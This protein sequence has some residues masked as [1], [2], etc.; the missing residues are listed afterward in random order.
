LYFIASE[1]ADGSF[2]SLHG[3]NEVAEDLRQVC[4]MKYYPQ[5]IMNY[6]SCIAANYSNAG[7]IWQTC[8]SSNGIDATQIQE[9]STGDEGNALLSDNIALSNY[10]G[11]YESPTLLLNNN[12]LVGGYYTTS[13]EL[14]KEV[15][16]AY[17]PAL[18]GCNKTLSGEG[19]LNNSY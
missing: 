9:C 4:I 18:N 13:A 15:V 6:T 3:A 8:A 17:N 12:T 19:I 5:K 16:C 7:G 2:T 14:M 11:I 10:L 1:N